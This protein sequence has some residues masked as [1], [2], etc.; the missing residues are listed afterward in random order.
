MSLMPYYFTKNNLKSKK[1]KQK[2]TISKHDLWLLENGLHLEQIK[3]KK[4]VDN[5]WKECYKVDTKNAYKSG[6]EFRNCY[7]TSIMSNLHKEPPEVRKEIIRKAQ[8]VAIPY[9]KGAYQYISDSDDVKNLG[10]KT[11]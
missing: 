1:K 9:S 11:A 7:D 6:G 4:R 8:R 2:D 3:H 10:K 5:S